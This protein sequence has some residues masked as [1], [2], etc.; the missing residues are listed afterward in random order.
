[1][2]LYSALKGKAQF[3]GNEAIPVGLIRHL[4]SERK[5]RTTS[6]PVEQVKSLTGS[7]RSPGSP[8]SLFATFS[9]LASAVRVQNKG[10][11]R[12]RRTQAKEQRLAAALLEAAHTNNQARKTIL[13]EYV[14]QRSIWSTGFQGLFAYKNYSITATKQRNRETLKPVFALTKGRKHTLSSGN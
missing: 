2:S 5:F 8:H 10:E 13:R 4:R 3:R 6:R 7:P 9:G 1:M 12:G 14:G 11:K